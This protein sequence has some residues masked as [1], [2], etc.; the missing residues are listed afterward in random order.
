MSR[1]VLRNC[2][3]MSLLI[4]GSGVSMAQIQADSLVKRVKNKLASVSDYQGEGTMKTEVSFMKVP[5]SKVTVYYKKPDKFRI[6]KE[7]GIS[8]VPKGGVNINIGAL[9][10]GDNYTAVAAGKGSVDGNPVEIIKLL[11]LDEKNQV[12]V[13][14][15]YINEKEALV[16]KATVSTRDNG[17]YELEMNYGKFAG[18]GLPDKVIFTFTTKDYKL[19]KGLAF[20]YDTGEKPKNPV[21]DASQK[22]KV[23]IRYSN[24]LINK[25]LADNLF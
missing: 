16:Q 24:Y 15:L 20:D 11:P 19:P 3:L 25:G 22:G 23:E 14:T 8:I 21:A 5:E 2:L 1:L 12:V 10:M 9:F 7:N 17:T 6:K 18:W 13:S 4:T